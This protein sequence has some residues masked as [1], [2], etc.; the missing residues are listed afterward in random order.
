[1]KFLG[2]LVLST[3]VLLLAAQ[4]A[5]ATELIIQ[6][7]VSASRALAGHVL[8]GR[9]DEPVDD[10]TVQLCSRDWKTVFTSV[11]TDKNGYFSLQ[12]PVAGSLFYIRFSAPGMDIYELR[13]RIKKH[14]VKELT[15]HLSVAT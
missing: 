2:W 3:L 5:H 7:K 15:I 8:V 9:T 12:Q 14:A 13:V 10:V 6:E 1:M 4:T 11:K